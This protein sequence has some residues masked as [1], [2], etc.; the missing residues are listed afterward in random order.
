MVVNYRQ[1]LEH[2]SD[3]IFLLD[4]DGY[5]QYCNPGATTLTGYS[6]NDLS[7]QSMALLRSGGNDLIHA[8]YE[9]TVALR[10][11]VTHSKGWIFRKEGSHFWG[12]MTITPVFDE[13]QVCTGYT[14]VLRDSTAVLEETIRLRDNEERYRLMVEGVK[15]YAIFL[16]DTG[17]HIVTWNEGAQRTKGYSPDE[18]IGKHFS[19]FYTAEDLKDGKPARELKIAV[20]TGKYEEQ[21]WRVK[22]DGSVFWANVVITALFNERNEHIGF[23]KVTRDLTET[24]YQQ[25]A[26]RESEERY[27]SLVEQ[28][29]DYGIFMM[30]EKGRI[31]SWNTGAQRINGYTTEEILGKYFSIFYTEEDILSGKPD[32]ELRTALAVGKYEE[33]GWRLRKDGSKF[34]ANVVITAL[35]SSEKVFMGFSKVTRDLTERKQAELALRESYERFR[36]LAHTLKKTNTELAYANQELE[37][38]TSIVSHDLQEPI[39]TIKSYLQLLDLKLDAEQNTDLKA[40]I[41][42]TIH[43]ANRMRELIQNLLHYSQLSRGEILEVTMPT[44]ELIEQ[45]L[46]NLKSSIER[47]QPEIRIECEVD[48]VKGDRVQLVQL[49]QNLLSNALKF[50]D[51]EKPLITIWCTEVEGHVKFSVSDNGI[52]IAPGDYA[53]VFDMFRRLHTQKEYPGTGIG[54]TICKKI[55]DRHRGKI[56]LESEAGQGTTF[57]F[58]LYEN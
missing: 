44:A 45:A 32:F 21:G 9:R 41:S 52:G 5:I 11:G 39:R 58:T 16:L 17:G 38:F 51:A 15:E 18:I 31:V 29:G 54:L 30:D 27:R 4:A 20:A 33:E 48:V 35:Y 3:A 28:V 7:H 42:R 25:E 36:S 8:E 53:K 1:I 19:T 40:Y 10:Q 14:C 24:K 6:I 26:L 47:T 56:W 43:A 57:H 55:V 37:Q 12:E 22:K 34:W 2:I 23:S 49:L 46:Q 50:T 13:E